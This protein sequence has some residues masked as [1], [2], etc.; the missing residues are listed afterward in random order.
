MRVMTAA[1]PRR[2]HRLGRATRAPPPAAAAPTATALACTNSSRSAATRST[3]PTCAPSPHPP[4]LF[5]YICRH[6]QLFHSLFV[7]SPPSLQA[8]N[9]VVDTHSPALY[10]APCSR[11]CLCQSLG[12]PRPMPCPGQGARPDFHMRLGPFSHP[13]TQ[14]ATSLQR[15]FTHQ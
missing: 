4:S 5:L 15:R 1:G 2:R 3:D 10:S 6:P 7:Y 11:L 13:G 9:R 14:S 8:A 12:L